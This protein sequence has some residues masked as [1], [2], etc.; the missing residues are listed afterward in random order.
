MKHENKYSVI[1]NDGILTKS[2]FDNKLELAD[3]LSNL[4]G[5]KVTP[6]TN[7]PKSLLVECINHNGNIIKN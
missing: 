6:S 4:E 5:I 3:I 7:I 1:Y 2:C